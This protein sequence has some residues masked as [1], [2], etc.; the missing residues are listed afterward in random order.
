M[1]NSPAL[2]VNNLVKKY[3]K[4]TAVDGVSFNIG[5]GEFFGFLGP[6]GAGKTS[7]I[8]AI[9]GIGSFQS[10]HITVFGFDVVKEYRDARRKIGLSPQ[11]FNVDSFG[12]PR[13]MLDFVGG[14]FEMPKKKRIERMAYLLRL[15]GMES[16]ADTQFRALS[17]GY[18]RRYMLAR[19]MMHDPELLILDEPTAGVDVEL[20]HQLWNILTDLNKQGKTIFLTTHYLEEA[21][22]LCERIGIIFN[23][24]IVALE[25][26]N[27]LIK[28]GKSVEDHYLRFAEMQKNHNNQLK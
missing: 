14:Y 2:E 23:G 11:E 8:S 25:S 21:Q 15:L 10:G 1:A 22:K 5:K 28:D 26:K 9:T 16:Y 17:G 3:G 4:Q 12:T 20:R 18:K 13:K 7:T 27:E 19:A 24:K 6:N